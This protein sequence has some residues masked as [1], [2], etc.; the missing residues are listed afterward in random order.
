MT[1]ARLLVRVRSIGIDVSKRRLVRLLINKK[2]LTVYD[3]GA[4]HKSRNDYCTQIDN[5]DFRWCGSTR[6]PPKL[7]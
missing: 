4:R 3:T 6:S 2:G 1:G 7:H 5:E